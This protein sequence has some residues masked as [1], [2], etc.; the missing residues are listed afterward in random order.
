MQNDI[1]DLPGDL[2]KLCSL[3][4]SKNLKGQHQ[5]TANGK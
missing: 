1:D 2:S 5:K 4:T 3:R